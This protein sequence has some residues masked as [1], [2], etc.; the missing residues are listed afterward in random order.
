MLETPFW[1]NAARS[2]PAH[3]R[4]RYAGQLQAAERL[5]LAIDEV[6]RLIRNAI[7]RDG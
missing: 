6:V 3:V 5:D 2:L 7:A 1:R 4:E